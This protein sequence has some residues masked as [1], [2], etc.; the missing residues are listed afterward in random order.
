MRPAQRIARS[1][2]VVIATLT[3]LPVVALAMHGE[4][5]K[6]PAYYD[7]T[8]ITVMMGPSGNSSNPNQAPSP[9]FGLGPDFSQTSRSAEVPAFYGLFLPG[10]TQ[11]S[12]PDGTRRH[13]MV[14]TAVPGDPDYNAAIELVNCFAGPSFNIADMP[15]TSAAAVQAGIAASELTCVATGRILL[16]PVVN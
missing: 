10:A 7:G 1:I 11:M 15:Y 12:C 9:C 2:S 6:F 3:L 8:V 5:E 4:P 14:V 16:S 13:D